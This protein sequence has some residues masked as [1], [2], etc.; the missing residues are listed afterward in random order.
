MMCSALSQVTFKTG[1]TTHLGLG[2]C[3]YP[4]PVKRTGDLNTKE[5]EGGVP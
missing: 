4:E 5:Y 3:F 2:D 1:G